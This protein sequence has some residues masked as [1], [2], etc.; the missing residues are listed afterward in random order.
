MNERKLNPIAMIDV[1]DV[2]VELVKTWIQIYNCDYSDNLSP[3][4]ITDWDIASFVVPECKLKIYDYLSNPNLNIYY[5]AEQVPNSL[6]GVEYLRNIGYR[7]VF[8]TSYDYNMNKF[9]WLIENKY[10][11]MG[12]SDDYVIAHDKSLIKCNIMVDDGIHNVEKFPNASILFNRP[13]NMKFEHD[14]R[15][16]N[17]QEII[18]TFEKYRVAYN[19]GKV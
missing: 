2:C 10:L 15:V 16:N 19:L 14:F 5:G 6:K 12:Q 18:D 3:E 11:K 8:C 9:N 1:D 17:W 7:I 4:E 13:W